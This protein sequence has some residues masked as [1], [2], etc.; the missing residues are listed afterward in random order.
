VSILRPGSGGDT[1]E[2]GQKVKRD[3]LT[4]DTLLDLLRFVNN[5][6]Q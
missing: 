3:V 2:K 5:N 6:F 4:A 1:I